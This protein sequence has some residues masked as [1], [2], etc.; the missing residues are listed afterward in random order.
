MLATAAT[1]QL[2]QT[3]PLLSKMDADYYKANKAR[4]EPKEL[5][6][7]LVTVTKPEHARQIL[8]CYGVAVIPLPVNRQEM[9]KALNE[10]KFYPSLSAS[11]AICIFLHHVSSS[12]QHHTFMR[13]HYLYECII[14]LSTISMSASFRKKLKNNNSIRFRNSASAKAT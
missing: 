14:C 4:F 2:K 13:I 7:K 3:N 5:P 12:S 9:L 10:T 8:N 1:Q 6:A 11:I